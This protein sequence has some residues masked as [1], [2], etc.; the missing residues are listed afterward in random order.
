MSTAPLIKDEVPM[1]L[2]SS[3]LKLKY[4]PMY[5][6]EF[7]PHKHDHHTVTQ[8]LPSCHM[9]VLSSNTYPSPP[10]P[11]DIY[12][13]YSTLYSPP[14]SH[15]SYGSWDYHYFPNSSPTTTTTTTTNPSSSPHIYHFVCPNNVYH[16][17]LLPPPPT[18]IPHPY[19]STQ[20]YPEA[21]M[22]EYNPEDEAREWK[23]V[24]CYFTSDDNMMIP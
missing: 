14:P 1:I 9:P 19:C 20:G 24:L 12:P 16:P 8:E 23:E 6:P 17:P 15:P 22:Q 10:P 11:M 7:H 2:A 5:L 21:L 3:E 18:A 13:T 4:P